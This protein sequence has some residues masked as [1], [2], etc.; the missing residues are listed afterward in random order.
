MLKGSRPNWPHLI[1]PTSHLVKV[2]WPHWPIFVDRIWPDRIWPNFFCGVGCSLWGVR[3]GVF[4]VGVFVVEGVRRESG[5]FEGEVGCSK[6]RCGVRRGGVFEG[7]GPEGWGPRRVGGPKFRASFSLSRGN[8]ILSFLSEG[9]SR[10]IVAVVQ[11]HGPPKMR[12]SVGVILCEPR[13]QGGVRER[14]PKIL[15]TPTTHNT[16]THTHNTQQ[17]NN[18]TTTTTIIQSG[19]APF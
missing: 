1:W 8:F 14:G 2:N 6:G 17:H 3:C 16:L 19:E 7:W 5:V 12:V 18:T 9:S 10:G 13:I 11:G 15:N 4:V